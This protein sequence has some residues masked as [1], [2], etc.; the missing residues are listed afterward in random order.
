MALK[1]EFD[2]NLNAQNDKQSDILERI[3]AELAAK[4]AECE[5][6]VMEKNMLSEKLTSTRD[7][8]IRQMCVEE[9]VRLQN[10]GELK[11]QLLLATENNEVLKEILNE[12]DESCRRLEIQL[13]EKSEAA[14]RLQA[15]CAALE[16]DVEQ[17][18]CEILR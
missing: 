11:S 4:A 13:R 12:R 2:E 3:R 8:E 17:L 16:G 1:R 6:L 14:S 9:D 10:L 18:N 7:A 5:K 15:V